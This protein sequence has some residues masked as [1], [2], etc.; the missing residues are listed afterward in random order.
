VEQ[1]PG[2]DGWLLFQPVPEPKAG[3]NRLHLDLTAD[4]VPRQIERLVALGATLV[5]ERSDDQ[6]RWWVF[7][8]PEGNLF[9]LG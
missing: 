3:K 9:C 2:L 6:Y 7:S 4:D 8:D 1:V 5:E